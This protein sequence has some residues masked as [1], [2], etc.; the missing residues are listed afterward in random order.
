MSRNDDTGVHGET[1]PAMRSRQRLRIYL[2]R[3]AGVL[4]LF[5]F[6]LALVID[7]LNTRDEDDVESHLAEPVADPEQIRRGAYL[8]RAGNCQSC[9]TQAGAAPY[10]GGEGIQTP[11]G[12]VY[13]GNLTPDKKTGLGSWNASNFWRAMHNGRSKDGRWLYPAFPYAQYTR[14]TRADADDIFAYLRSLP[15]VEQRNRDHALRFPYNTQMALALWRALYFK[16]QHHQVASEQSVQWNRGLYL[17]EG[18]GHCAA[19]HSP[20]NALGAAADKDR[21]LRGSMMPSEHWYAPSLLAMSEAGVMDWPATDVMQLLQS[22]RVGQ[23]HVSGPMA[24]VVFGSTQYLTDDDL[25]AMAVYLKN[26]PK[27]ETVIAPVKT[28]DAMELQH[29]ARLY[30]KHCAECHGD[31]GEGKAGMYPALRGNRTVTMQNTANLISVIRQGGFGPVTEKNPRP[32]GMP[33]FGHV[34]SHREMANVIT[35]LRQSW[36]NQASSVTELDVLRGR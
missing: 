1:Q 31:Q 9:H 11:F 8:A 5:A 36:G 27:T 14:L 10:A 13:A 30:D 4:C 33:P 19:C 24:S 35:F 17:V 3:V 15:A 22:G 32:Y 23:A 34:L 18:L 20:R 28:A 16:P 7:A 2:W 29:G 6:G 12:V 26:L 25:A 21:H